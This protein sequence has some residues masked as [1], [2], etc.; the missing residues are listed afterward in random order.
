MTMTAKRFNTLK[1]RDFENGAIRDEIYLSLKKLQETI[2]TLEEIRDI[3][4][5]S[6]KPDSLTERQY[7]EMKMCKIAREASDALELMDV[8]LDKVM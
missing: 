3:A 8:K 1:K 4:R 6:L 5:S 2:E 7:R